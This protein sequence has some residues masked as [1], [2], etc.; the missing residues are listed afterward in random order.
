M[1]IRTVIVDD[2]PLSR[3]RM[4]ALLAEEPDIEVI[5]QCDDGEAAIAT[6][7]R[8]NPDLVFLDVQMPEKNGFEVLQEVPQAP[9]VI[10]V[11]AY[12]Q[13]ALQAFEVHALDFLLKP[14]D[15]KRL[16]NAV[17]RAREQILRQRTGELRERLAAL[18]DDLKGN[19]DRYVDRLVVKADGRVFFIKVDEVD[20]VEAAAN[21]VRLHTR[22]GSHLIRETMTT[23]EARLDPKKFLRIH[24][25]A[26]VRI[27]AI[28]ELQPLFHGDYAVLLRSGKRLAASRGYRDRLNHLLA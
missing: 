17:E 22:S 24:R 23:I 25:S 18:L 12:D 10:F 5:A 13:Y 4:L 6:I 8:T 7:A 21:Y 3:D 9:A 14:F 28:Q 16:R 27:D 2:E 26:I 11:T 1:S 20:W 15:R 19:E